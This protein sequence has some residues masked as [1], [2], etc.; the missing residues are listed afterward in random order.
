MDHILAI[1]LGTS[2]LKVLVMGSDAS[3]LSVAAVPYRTDFPHPGWVQQEPEE[4]LKA[5]KKG[6]AQTWEKITPKAV[7]AISFSGH[8]SGVVLLDNTGDVL[9]PCITLADARSEPECR[10][11]KE[12][13]AEQVLCRTGNPVINAFA[14]PKLLWMKN[15][16]DTWNR[17]RV[18]VSPKDYLRYCLTGKIETEYTDAYNSLFVRADSRDWDFELIREAGVEAEK[19]PQITAPY[20]RSGSVTRAAAQAF[21]LREGTPVYA[22]AADM[23]CGAVGMNLSGSGEGVITL[24]TSATF[25]LET[26]G[27][28]PEAGGAVTY[29]LNVL[30]GEM[31]ALGSHF[32]GGLVL[33]CFSRLFSA[34]GEINYEFLRQAAEEAAG[35]PAGSN[36]ILTIPFLAGSGSPYFNPRDRGTVLGLHANTSRGELMRSALEGVACNLSQTLSLFERLERRELQRIYLGGGGIHIRLWPSIFADLMGREIC[37]VAAADASAAGAAI[38]GG[39]GA[40]IFADLSMAASAFCQVKERFAPDRKSHERYK[41]YK[42]EYERAYNLAAE[43]YEKREDD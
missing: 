10:A 36:G 29:H 38:I 14:A 5:L 28:H 30:P 11:L 39:Y 6:L 42:R 43:F 16:T 12:R 40:G 27:F 25:L 3:V 35:I 15:H 9:Q 4:W 20:S 26:T 37:T 24:G 2:A 13:I 17:V 18:W 22:G 8:M 21:G 33:N 7:S 32:N 19:F 1:D 31:Y 23:A 41:V 34:D